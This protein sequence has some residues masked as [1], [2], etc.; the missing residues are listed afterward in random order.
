VQKGILEKMPVR[1]LW[2]RPRKRQRRSAAELPGSAPPPQ[3]AGET[4]GLT[5]SNLVQ[6]Q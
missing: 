6:S 5:F 2:A 3:K 1:R 4:Y